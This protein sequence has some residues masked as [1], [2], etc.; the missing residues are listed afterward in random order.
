MTKNGL[1]V[2]DSIQYA[3]DLSTNESMLF[4]Y[5]LIKYEEGFACAQKQYSKV[6]VYVEVE[7]YSKYKYVFLDINHI[8]L[9]QDESIEIY[10]RK[11]GTVN[12]YGEK[13]ITNFLILFCIDT[14]E[15]IAIED[16]FSKYMIELI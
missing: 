11:H 5:P 15:L 4:F 8:F 3:K 1:Y 9:V 7:K 16:Y 2:F 6:N 13:E 12:E 10:N 14:H